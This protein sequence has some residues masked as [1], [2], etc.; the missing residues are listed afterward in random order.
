MSKVSVAIGLAVAMAGVSAIP[1]HAE[2]VPVGSTT[3]NSRR[4]LD[5]RPGSVTFDGRFAGGGAV[6]GGETIRVQVAG[7]IN[8]ISDARTAMLNVTEPTQAG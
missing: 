5:T 2:E 3:V 7:R 6:E 1:A 8:E 4:L